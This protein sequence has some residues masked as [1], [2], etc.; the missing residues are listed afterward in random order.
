MN[1]LARGHLRSR[2]RSTIAESTAPGSK[3]DERTRRAYRS[4]C[5]LAREKPR[6]LP[7]GML[8]LSLALLCGFYVGA[9]EAKQKWV[10]LVIGHAS[11]P[12]APLKNPV[13]AAR[14]IGARP[15]AF[16]I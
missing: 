2:P 13:N 10:A 14:A 9:T 11:Y 12:K 6:T 3:V 1:D 7:A 16:R 4:G 8:T 5:Q 15:V